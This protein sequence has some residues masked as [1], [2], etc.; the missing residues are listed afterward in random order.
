MQEL[1]ESADLKPGLLVARRFRLLRPAGRGGMASVWVAHHATLGSEV[2]LKFVDVQ[3]EGRAEAL[4]RFEREAL[5]VARLRSSHVVQI[6]DYGVDE[7][8]RP[9]IV[10][11]LLRGRSLREL[12]AEDGTLSLAVTARIVLSVCRALHRA[13]TAGIVHRDIKP[14]NI[15][16]CEEE[17]DGPLVKVLDFG[18]A[19]SKVVD[20]H[21]S[22]ETATGALVGT[23]AF[24]SP[25]QALGRPDI[26]GR[27]D[28]FS[29][30]LVAWRCLVGR[31]AHEADGKRLTLGEHIVAASTMTVPPP[32]AFVAELPPALDAWFA[33]A[34]ALDATKRF[35]SARAMAAAFV[36]ACPMFGDPLLM[37]GH[38]IAGADEID[39]SP[40]L[41]RGADATRDDFEGGHAAQSPQKRTAASDEDGR[42]S[43][44][45]TEMVAT[46]GSPASPAS[47]EENGGSAGS[48]L[49]REHGGGRALRR[50]RMVALGLTVAATVVAMA[51]VRRGVETPAGVV[52]PSGI[53]AN[54]TS[55]LPSAPIREE[56]PPPPRAIVGTAVDAAPR[57]GDE[58]RRRTSP[59]LDAQVVRTAPTTAPAPAARAVEPEKSNLLDERL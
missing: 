34:L 12:L 1:A 17:E 30:G 20:V 3:G 14:A 48:P 49:T 59:V 23:P 36:S 45:V 52:V 16:L 35:E 56:L 22:H 42:A 53:S 15:F 26:D 4:R 8:D 44:V 31:N 41:Q 58:S 50:D 32:S 21:D 25:E 29:L 38:A 7:A 43:H 33:R 2:A 6:L 40:P 11:E 24:M 54:A 27:S 55:A 46:M 19:K 37:R 57:A 10:M 18:L 47:A 5:V 28:L 9:Y 51:F 13:H 39:A